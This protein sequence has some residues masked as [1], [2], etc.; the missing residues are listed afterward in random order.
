[1]KF[2]KLFK[3]MNFLRFST[4]N[5][6]LMRFIVG[7]FSVILFCVIILSG[8]SINKI[9]QVITANTNTFSENQLDTVSGTV[10]NALNDM[11]RTMHS[12][13][14]SSDTSDIF[15]FNAWTDR[16]KNSVDF[17]N[18]MSFFRNYICNY[19]F[20]QSVWVL[21]SNNTVIDSASSAMQP[22][23]FEYWSFMSDTMTRAR[24]EYKFM[25]PYIT[26]VHSIGN[27]S[28]ISLASPLKTGDSTFSAGMIMIN[29]KT[30]YLTEKLGSSVLDSNYMSFIYDKAENNLVCG[31]LQKYNA[32]AIISAAS[33]FNDGGAVYTID[34]VKY[35]AYMKHSGIVPEWHFLILYNN[36]YIAEQRRSIYVWYTAAIIILVLFCLFSTWFITFYIY[37]PLQRIINNLRI[38]IED[39]SAPEL[40]KKNDEIKIIT[41]HI[42]TLE[43][44]LNDKNKF[45]RDNISK[46]RDIAVRK[47]I[48]TPNPDA[49]AD[50]SDD[51]AKCGIVFTEKYY[52]IALCTMDRYISFLTDRTSKDAESLS[53][54]VFD[55]IYNAL[56]HTVNSTGICWNKC[57]YV[58]IL[59]TDRQISAL[60]ASEALTQINEQLRDS[61]GFT[62]SLCLS[63]PVLSPNE[64]H[65]AF[66]QARTQ[67]KYRFSLGN[68]SL[69]F[70]PHTQ[71]YETEDSSA[72]NSC[73]SNITH[74]LPTKDTTH[75]LTE[76][77]KFTDML[78]PLSPDDVR[79]TVI[80]LI[81]TIKKTLHT[82]MPNYDFN[83]LYMQLDTL[84][85]Y[86]VFVELR[87]FLP[88]KLI[89]ISSACRDSN[90]MNTTQRIKEYIDL[91]YY[92]DL[93]LDSLSDRFHVSSSYISKTF[94][95]TYNTGFQ[96]YLSEL[97]ISKAK[98]LLKNTDL[99][100]QT[101]CER[102]GFMS[103]NSFSR[104]FKRITGIS[105]KAYRMN[106]PQ[107]TDEKN[108]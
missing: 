57:K 1:M 45:I 79:K 49:S 65:S 78:S 62:V 64:L 55:T 86:S 12:M 68:E 42:S 69:I 63:E 61:C 99:S 40:N 32:S 77:I 14:L 27:A 21:N 92:N 107:E 10:D 52:Y 67:E 81:D 103:Y 56:S 3:D 24:R 106:V 5:I 33:S 26:N 76:L 59:N 84:F 97:R 108:E 88:S 4:K 71:Y 94:A 80:K 31:S 66:E 13:S 15:N 58:F 98:E 46:I 20:I 87:D 22:S 90:D 60:R 44:E 48:E 19:D 37:K 74:L 50:L 23:E 25:I 102:V 30:N 95:E 8:I 93:S 38:N 104:T 105:A 6:M 7:N 18:W 85:S 28:V 100:I 11:F 73:I 39:M 17:F 35:T 43:N 36:N 53:A 47:I 96:S 54:K 41:S 51:L 91:Y 34:G 101:I 29:I 89:E 83:L 70:C 2:N 82:G 16:D 72:L 75:I 9:N